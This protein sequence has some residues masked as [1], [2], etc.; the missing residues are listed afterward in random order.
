MLKEVQDGTYA[1]MW[2]DEN[3]K[4]RPW[5]NKR[6]AEE[7]NQ[8]LEEGRQR[9]AFHDALDEPEGRAPGQLGEHVRTRTSQRPVLR[10]GNAGHLETSCAP[11]SDLRYDSA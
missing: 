10:A 9:A 3:A 6:R 1:K 4:G 11:T 2:L 8:Q 5:F 7:R